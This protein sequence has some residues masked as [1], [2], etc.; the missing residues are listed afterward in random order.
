MTD[1]NCE[2]NKEELNSSIDSLKTIIDYVTY[3][4][5]TFYSI[6]SLRFF[7]DLLREKLG[8]N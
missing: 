6:V 8:K 5:Q 7:A 1:R 2:I 3:L 4:M